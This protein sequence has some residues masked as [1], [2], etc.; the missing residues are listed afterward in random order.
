MGKYV[1]PAIFTKENDGKY[2]IIFPDLEGCYTTGDDLA[3]G[4]YMAQDV[5]AFTLYSL[6]K[7]NQ[8]VP[9][10][11]DSIS[12]PIGSFINYIACDTFEYHKKH[13]TKAVKKTVSI[14]E[15]LNEEAIKANL[16]FSQILQEA[17]KL[18]LEVI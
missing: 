6:E 4:I 2:S 8:P 16:N 11:S 3:D 15:W 10:A 1:Y 17:L 13:N 12:A 7:R 9:N 5:L 18:K 14:P